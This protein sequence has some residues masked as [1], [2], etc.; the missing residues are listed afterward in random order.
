LYIRFFTRVSN[1]QE[2]VE[3]LQPLGKTVKCGYADKI[4]ASGEV[5]EL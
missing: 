3:L 5:R 4:M 2:N 1:A